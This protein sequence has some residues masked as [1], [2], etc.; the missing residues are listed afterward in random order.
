[1]A[2]TQTSDVASIIEKRVSGIVTETLIQESVMMGAVNDYTSQIGPGM[3]RLDIPLFTELAVQDVS[4]SAA[5]TAQTIS[6]GVGQLNLDRHKSI[7]FAISDKAMTQAKANLVA[8]T[9]KNGARSLA[10]EI[11]DYILGLL[12]AGA[13]TAAPD[14]RQALTADPLADLAL[15]KKLLDDQNVPKAMRYVV[16]SPGFCQALLGTNNVINA[17]KYG[18]ENP[19]QAGYVSRIYGFTIL[20][21]SSSSIVDDGFIA[22]HRDTMAFGRQIAP[23]FERQRQV[24]KQADDYALTHLYGAVNTDSAGTRIVVFDSDGI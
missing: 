20:E 19:I 14:H 17:E 9:V 3:D 24:L 5:M 13:S 12:D 21:S 16:A 8:E 7:P 4:E 23:K 10:A 18:S 11:D 22:Y 2:Q 6:V 1:M 15:A